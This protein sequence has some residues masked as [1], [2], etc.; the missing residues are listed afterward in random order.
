MR[1]H[2]ELDE[3]LLEK[4]KKLIKT[5]QD[6]EPGKRGQIIYNM[7]NQKDPTKRV[8]I[9][10]LQR[11]SIDTQDLKGHKSTKNSETILFDKIFK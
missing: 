8:N 2:D 5:L 10:A 4:P 11:T 9:E 6:I 1:I 7:Y 3:S